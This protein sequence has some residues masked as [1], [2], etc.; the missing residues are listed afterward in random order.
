MLVVQPVWTLPVKV[1]DFISLT[2]LPAFVSIAALRLICLLALVIP[3]LRGWL[4]V[5]L[6]T[7][8]FSLCTGVGLLAYKNR[9]RLQNVIKIAAKS[10]GRSY[11]TWK[12]VKSL[13][14]PPRKDYSCGNFKISINHLFYFLQCN[15][16]II[17][18]VSK[19]VF[20]FKRTLLRS[21]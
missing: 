17:Y 20:S 19:T 12:K 14:P 8:T 4:E 11:V 7:L 13:K 18:Y 6:H 9:H 10:Q 15:V 3:N 1:T 16:Q 2:D 21:V 5:L